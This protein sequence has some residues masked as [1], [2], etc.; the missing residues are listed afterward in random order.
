MLALYVVFE[1]ANA[2]VCDYPEAYEGQEGFDFIQKVP[3][4]LG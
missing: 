2:M 4:Y 3:T 1:N